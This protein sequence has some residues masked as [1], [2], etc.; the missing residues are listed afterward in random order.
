[1]FGPVWR[2]FII[3]I[4]AA[5]CFIITANKRQEYNPLKLTL[6]ENVRLLPMLPRLSPSP[7]HKRFKSVKIY[8]V[9]LLLSLSG[10]VELN[11]GPGDISNFID[12]QAEQK[13][14]GDTIIENFVLNRTKALKKKDESLNRPDYSITSRDGM[15]VTVKL[16][17]A[18]FELFKNE[19]EGFLEQK[20]LLVTTK[21]T[22]HDRT[23]LVTKTFMTKF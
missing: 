5:S 15:Q 22:S 10:D 7:T 11:P 1:M 23:R 21:K 20:E 14:E 3:F 16:N 18:L 19:F 13:D 6:I 8:L 12:G 2:T 4:I 17:T 9:V